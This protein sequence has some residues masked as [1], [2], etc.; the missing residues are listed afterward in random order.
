[1]RVSA[2]ADYALRAAAEL[3]AAEGKGPV[4]GEQLARAQAIP[5]KFLE[6]ILLELRH[7]GLV[8]SQRGA[9][10]GYWLARPAEE[11]TLAEVIRAV[12]GPLAN[13]RG[14]RPESLEYQGTAEPLRN[15]WIA[16]R[17]SLRRVLESVTLADVAHGE[18]PASLDD[19][20]ADPE[21]W[22]PH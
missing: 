21:A 20:V 11:I 7:A 6:N 1:V 16:V 19:L 12:E 3:A 4:K 8:Q 15:V 14:T 17:A 10:G 18:L 13:V 2:K 22:R 9:E 5:A